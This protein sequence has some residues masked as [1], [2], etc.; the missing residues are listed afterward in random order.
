[1][2]EESAPA[3]DDTSLT[4]V[5]EALNDPDC[6]AILQETAEPMTAT[7]LI[8]ACDIPKSTLY[9]KLDRLGSAALLRERDTIHPEGGRTTTYARDFDNVLIAIEDDDS[10]S[11]AVDRPSRSADERL[12]DIWSAMGDEL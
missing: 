6:R 11:V 3:P 7:E 9:R 1:M 12:A 8:D 4:A 10:F 2:A 5:L